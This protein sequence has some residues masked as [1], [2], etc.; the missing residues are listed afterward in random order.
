MNMI[1][2][3][4]NYCVVEFRSDEGSFAQGYEIMDKSARKELYLAGFMAQCFRQNV[5]TL[6]AAEP[7]VEQVDSFLSQFEGLMQQPLVL[8]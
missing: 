8:H 3:S 1:Y 4:A 2:N 5:E 7:S 6:I